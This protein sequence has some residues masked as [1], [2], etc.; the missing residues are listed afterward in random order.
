[1][2]VLY[3]KQINTNFIFMHLVLSIHLLL[4]IKNH[5]T[6]IKINELMD[7]PRLKVK[8]V[9]EYIYKKVIICCKQIFPLMFVSFY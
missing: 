9:Q 1:M 4:I 8:D 2:L 5:F 6:E 7:A 3:D